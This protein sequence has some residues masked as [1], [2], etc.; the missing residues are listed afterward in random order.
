MTGKGAIDLLFS[1]WLSFGQAITA[2]KTDFRAFLLTKLQQAGTDLW[3]KKNWDWVYNDFDLVLKANAFEPDKVP[4][5]FHSCN[6]DGAVYTLNAPIYNLAWIEPRLMNRLLKRGSTPTAFT[7][8]TPLAYTS[9]G[10]TL[11]AAGNYP[12]GRRLMFWPVPVKDTNIRITYKSKPPIFQDLDDFPPVA[13]ASFARSAGVATIVTGTAH[14]LVQGQGV[15]IIGLSDA[16]FDGEFVV[17]TVVD[18]TTFTFNNAGP[19][20]GTTPDVVAK[21]VYPALSNLSAI[22]DEYHE[23]ILYYKAVS[24][25]MDKQGDGRSAVYEAKYIRALEEAWAD[26]QQGQNQKKRWGNRYGSRSGPSGPW[27][28]TGAFFGGWSI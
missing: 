14:N 4:P 12:G 26:E 8:R 28:Y 10:A 13:S 27:P 20:V 1:D 22:P 2:Q 16:S 18:P 6:K 21:A 9:F 17:A 7:Q 3:L 24:F 11:D 19:D 25:M 23:T 15:T 5:D